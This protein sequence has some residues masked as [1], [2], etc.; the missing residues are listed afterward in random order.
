MKARASADPMGPPNPMGDRCSAMSK[1]RHDRCKQPAIPGGTVCRY[2]GGAAPQV[3]RAARE[4][5]LAYQNRAIDRLFQLVEQ[6][7]FPST[8][9]AAV[10]GILDR[11][12]GKPTE[13]HRQPGVTPIEKLVILYQQAPGDDESARGGAG[14]GLSGPRQ[15]HPRSPPS[16]A[17]IARADPNRDRLP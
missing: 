5:L 10:R 4:R 6:K 14:V 9:F 8:A 11:T 1:Q 7:E 17:A 16:L 15:A 12:M 3:E 13:H 2:H